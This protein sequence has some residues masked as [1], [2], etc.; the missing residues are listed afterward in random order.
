MQKTAPGRPLG[1]APEAAVD[2]AVA[3]FWQHGVPGATTRAIEDGTGLSRSSLRNTFGSKQDLLAV[4]LQ[5]Y[6]DQVEQV[7]LAPMIEGEAGLDDAMAFFD[8][9]GARKR[10]EPGCWGCLAV[11]VAGESDNAAPEVDEQLRRYDR[12]LRAAFTAVLH[13]AV[14]RGEV[15]EG[16]VD[17]LAEVL[18]SQTVAV[19]WT[20]RALGS[21]AAVTSARA[22]S[23]LVRAWLLTG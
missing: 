19:N 21:E 9:L 3:V 13:R 22:A 17:T 11:V 7:L 20:A 8:E 1:F 14:D 5:R 4:A 10:D 23:D 16:A 2:D 15:A 18:R 6:V 12:L